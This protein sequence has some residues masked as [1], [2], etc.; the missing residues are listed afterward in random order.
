MRHIAE[1]THH[2]YK[3]FDSLK[4]KMC[5]WKSC[6]VMLDDEGSGN[7]FVFVLFF[8]CFVFLVLVV[9]GRGAHCDKSIFNWNNPFSTYWFH[10]VKEIRKAPSLSSSLHR[11]V[12]P[13]MRV[14][15]VIKPS[16]CLIP[17]ARLNIYQGPFYASTILMME[18]GRLS[19]SGFS[20]WFSLCA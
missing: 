5:L 16:C 12:F 17:S 18:M 2:T 9:E 10:S 19:G 13:L 20:Y 14:S 3:C 8:V 11:N 7:T 4:I 1:V 15:L 6:Y